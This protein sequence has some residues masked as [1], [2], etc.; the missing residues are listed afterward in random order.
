MKSKRMRRVPRFQLPGRRTPPKS[1][2]PEIANNSVFHLLRY[3]LSEP[4]AKIDRKIW[5]V[6]LKNLTEFSAWQSFRSKQWRG[7]GKLSEIPSAFAL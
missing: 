1:A 5:S 7:G 6:G 2:F 3:S 4:K